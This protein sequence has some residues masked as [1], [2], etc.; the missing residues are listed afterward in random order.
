MALRRFH[1]PLELGV[2]LGAK[3]FGG[4]DQTSKRCIVFD[5]ERYRFQK[6]IS[7]IAGQDIHAHSGDSQV[8]IEDL[9]AWLRGQSRDPAIPSGRAIAAEFEVFRAD[10]LPAICRPRILHL[11]ELTFGDFND[12]VVEYVASR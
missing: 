9:A 2:F 5:R 6:F 7:D 1:M 11:D 3:S 4:R 8:L 10:V 12:I